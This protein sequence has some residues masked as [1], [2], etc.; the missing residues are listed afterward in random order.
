M[1]FSS[2]SLKKENVKSNLLSSLF[3]ALL[4]KNKLK[5]HISIFFGKKRQRREE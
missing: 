4:P 1:Q 2:Q 3:I 5:P